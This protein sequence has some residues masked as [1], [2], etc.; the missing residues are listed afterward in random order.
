MSEIYIAINKDGEQLGVISGM[1]MVFEVLDI[2]YIPNKAKIDH[3]GAF[4]QVGGFPNDDLRIII[5][6]N[7]TSRNVVFTEFIPDSGSIDGV[8]K[9]IELIKQFYKR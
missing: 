2:A 3:E 8:N 5:M 6:D 7:L 9:S 1:K 4:I